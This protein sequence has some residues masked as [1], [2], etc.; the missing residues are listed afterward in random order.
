MDDTRT[1]HPIVALKNTRVQAPIEQPDGLL[2]KR[3]AD[4]D[5]RVQ[6]LVL[7]QLVDYEEQDIVREQLNG[8]AAILF[9]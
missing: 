1:A 2:V 7:P 5:T 8:H 3:A 9:V 6:C 4:Q